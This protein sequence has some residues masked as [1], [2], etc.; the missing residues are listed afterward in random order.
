MEQSKR[1]ICHYIAVGLR[2]VLT[3]DA[4]ASVVLLLGTMYFVLSILV[5][6]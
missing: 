6:G 4:F 1:G 2:G 5:R 3:S